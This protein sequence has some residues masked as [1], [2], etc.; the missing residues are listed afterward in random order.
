VSDGASSALTEP[1]IAPPFSDLSAL[2]CS[3]LLAMRQAE[4]DLFDV[5]TSFAREGRHPVHDVVS[6]ADGAYTT[7]TRYPEDGVGGGLDNSAWYYHAHDPADNRQWEENGHFHC[8]GFADRINAAASPLAAPPNVDSAARGSV[9]LVALCVKSDGVPDRLFTLNRWA[10]DEWLYPAADVIPLLDEF[11]IANDARFNPASRWLSAMVRL[12]Q[13]QIAWL[14]HERD[15]MLLEHKARV[16][17][18]F[19]EDATVELTSLIS[20]DLDDHL[21]ALDHATAGM[22]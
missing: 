13:P 14:L 21:A 8:F 11:L 1:I 15:R 9:H 17:D 6:K 3:R 22:D 2:P 16:G 20:F 18:S 10:S 4:R 7:F 12:L 19:S 5:L